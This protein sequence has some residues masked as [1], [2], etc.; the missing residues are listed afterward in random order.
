M[1]QRFLALVW[2]WI[3]LAAAAAI[4]LVVL[5]ATGVASV[6][7]VGDV[8]YVSAGDS[9]CAGHKPCFTN[10]QAAVASAPRASTVRVATGYYADPDTVRRGYLVWIYSPLR[11][12]LPAIA[13]Q[14]TP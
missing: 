14:Y 3:F 7:D 13:R 1:H 10:I 2:S 8:V 5:P 9:T 4:W 12:Q 6:L 11:L